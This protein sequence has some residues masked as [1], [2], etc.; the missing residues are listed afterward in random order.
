MVTTFSAEIQQQIKDSL[1]LLRAV[2]G[3]DLLGVYLYGSSLVGGLQRYSDLDLLVITSR[4]T[5]LDERGRLATALLHISGIYMKSVKLPIEMTLVEKAAINPWHYPPRFDFQYGDWLRTSFEQGDI[6]LW[7]T[8]EMPDLALIITQVLLKSHTLLG[9]EP[10]QLLPHVPYGD[11]IKAMV[12]DLSRLTADLEHD[13]RNVLL[14]YARI[15][16]TLRTNAIRSKPDA[17]DWV[18]QHLPKTHQPVMQRAK[19]ICIG[20]ENEHWDDIQLLIK[21]CAEFLIDKIQQAISLVNLNDPHSFI[22]LAE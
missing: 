16:S 11:F 14:T 6:D 7:A 10:K 20:V 15:W 19:L 3:A 13:T 8:H 22:R 4:A 21:P 12:D 2:L 5:T 9:L 18:I 1:N 17:A